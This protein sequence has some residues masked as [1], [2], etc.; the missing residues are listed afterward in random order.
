[1]KQN[2]INWKKKTLTDKE[3]KVAEKLLQAIYDDVQSVFE[4]CWKIR[5]LPMWVNI[6]KTSFYFDDPKSNVNKLIARFENLDEKENE[7]E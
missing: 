4:G 3:V 7:S 1:M 5:Y 2:K 6:W